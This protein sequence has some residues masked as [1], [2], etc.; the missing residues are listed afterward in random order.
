MRKTSC[1]GKP[2]LLKGQPIGMYHC[3]YCGAMVIAGLPHPS[4][5]EVY[6]QGDTPYGWN[7]LK[8]VSKGDLPK[9]MSAI[10][11]C[12]NCLCMTYTIEGL[13]GKCKGKK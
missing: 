5:A 10:S 3:E 12:P 7:K 11:Q 9:I 13:C 1:P 2:E 6:C 4:D 8:E